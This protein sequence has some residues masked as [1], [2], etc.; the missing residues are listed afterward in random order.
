VLRAGG[1]FVILNLSYRGDLELDR[2]DARDLAD[3][4]GLHLLR[5]GTMDLRLWDGVTFHLRKP[6]PGAAG[7]TISWPG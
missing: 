4:A 7:E 6:G 5:N 3:S 1:D 2:R